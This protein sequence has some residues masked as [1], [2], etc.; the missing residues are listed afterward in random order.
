MLKIKYYALTGSMGKTTLL[1]PLAGRVTE[2]P[3][4]CIELGLGKLG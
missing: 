2:S 1:I 3:A 4:G